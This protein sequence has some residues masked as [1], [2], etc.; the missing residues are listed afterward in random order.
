MNLFLILLILITAIELFFFFKINLF[1]FDLQKLIKE[2]FKILLSKNY[3]DEYKEQHLKK[4]SFETLKY[5]LQ[6]IIFIT[7]FLV[8]VYFVDYLKNDFIISFLNLKIILITT[9]ISIF[10]IKIRFHKK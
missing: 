4:Y 7:F 10:Y 3:S 2:I 6:I 8:V 5:S 1:F 9:I